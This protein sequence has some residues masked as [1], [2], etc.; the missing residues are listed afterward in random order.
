MAPSRS[1]RFAARDR[2]GAR[3]PA[4]GVIEAIPG[5]IGLAQVQ[6][7]DMSDP[8]RLAAVD[9]QYI[10]T[11]SKLLDFTLVLK[12]LTG[13]GQGDSAQRERRTP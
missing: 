13:A 3:P 10:E 2:R 1:Q 4:A 9:R 11:R 12:T 8:E 7:I 5:I 6:G